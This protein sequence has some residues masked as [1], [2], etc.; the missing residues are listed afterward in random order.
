MLMNNLFLAL[1]FVV[2]VIGPVFILMR[3]QG[4]KGN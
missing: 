4:A 2:T 3:S 1:A